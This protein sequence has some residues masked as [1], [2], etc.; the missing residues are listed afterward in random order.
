MLFR[1]LRGPLKSGPVLCLVSLTKE[2]GGHEV[3]LAQWIAELDRQGVRTV[4]IVEAG[5]QL[6]SLPLPASCHVQEFHGWRDSRLLGKLGKKVDCVRLF[7]LFL[8]LR[9]FSGINRVVVAEGSLMAQ[10]EATLAAKL[11]RNFTAVYCPLLQ[12]F[13]VT[14]PDG[15]VVAQRFFANYQRLPDLWITLSEEMAEEFRN[16]SKVTQPIEI[17]P[18]TIPIRHPIRTRP[19]GQDRKHILVMGRIAMMHKGL[20][21]LLDHIIENADRCRTQGWKFILAGDGHDRET[22]EARIREHNVEDI[23]ELKGWISPEAAYELADCLLLCSRF[24]GVPLV[25]LEAIVVGVP[26][27]ASDIPGTRAYVG[28]RC[29]FP[30]GDMK[31]AFS[32]IDEIFVSDSFRAS[33]MEFSRRQAI[34]L[35][36]HEAFSNSVTRLNREFLVG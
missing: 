18:N 4:L 30:V 3:M 34:Q 9:I 28:Q 1:F 26:V 24:E 8:R 23:V 6:L 35:A 31:A 5:K 11:A 25:M 21:F 12:H 19:G 7:F 20:D 27:V 15:D 16:W 13:T 17:L 29:R 14:H 22:I 36:S 10:V 32:I 2:F 33:E